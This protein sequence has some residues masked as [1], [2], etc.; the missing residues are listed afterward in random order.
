MQPVQANPV[1]TRP[2]FIYESVRENTGSAFV[3]RF[4][5]KMECK[6]AE[7]FWEAMKAYHRDRGMS[8]KEGR[9]EASQRHDSCLAIPPPRM[10][11]PSGKNGLSAIP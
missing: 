1:D 6:D 4:E 7:T 3:R 5:V 9:G 11:P 10:V 2:M 8:R